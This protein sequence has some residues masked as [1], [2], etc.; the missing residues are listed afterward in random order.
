MSLALKNETMLRCRKNMECGYSRQKFSHVEW[1]ASTREG[2][3]CTVTVREGEPY[4]TCNIPQLQK[5][6]CAHV[7]AACFKE[8]G[9]ANISTHSFCVPWHYVD[10]YRK[11]YAPMFHHVPD[12]QSWPEKSMD[13]MI[14]PLDVRRPPG[15][16]PSVRIRGTMNG[17]REGHRQNRCSK[18]KKLVWESYP[19]E[20]L[21]TLP[22]I[23]RHG[24]HI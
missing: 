7:I 5:L 23:C 17:E 13:Q 14:S 11:S 9:C 1:E 21:Q 22:P 20:V 18:Y 12:H 16:P 4:C 19:D 8:R 24:S 10:T 15:H 6:R 3:T 2:Y